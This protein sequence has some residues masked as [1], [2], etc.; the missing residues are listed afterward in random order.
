VSIYWHWLFLGGISTLLVL[1][2]A[3]FVACEFSLI[4]LRYSHFNPELLEELSN[5][6]RFAPLLSRV[7]NALRFL[8]LGVTLCTVGLGLVAWPA[9][10]KLSHL[11]GYPEASWPGWV[12]LIIILSGAIG[13]RHI[14]GELIPRAVALRFP[15]ETLRGTVWFV[16]VLKW[17]VSPLSALLDGGAR[18]ILKVLGIDPGTGWHLLD[19]EMQ[20]R[21][22]SEE[23]G[24]SSDFYPRILKSVLGMRELVV[25][26]VMLPRS[27][28]QY[29]DIYD[30]VHDNLMLAREA[31]HTRFPLCE[32]D[33]DNCIGIIHIKDIFRYGDDPTRV[34]FRRIRRPVIYVGVDDLLDGVMEKLLRQK[35]HMA[36]VRDEFGGTVGV[37]TLENLIEQM[38]GN[39]QDEFDSE[40]DLIQDLEGNSFQVDGLT[41]IRELEEKFGVEIDDDEVSTL[42]GVITSELGHIPETGERVVV[43]SLEIEVTEVD[44]RRVI[45]ARVKRIEANEQKDA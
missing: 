45:S 6:K 17:V 39:I 3:L 32:G 27:Q 22:L 40:E 43:N 13:L 1:V 31:G 42:G 35:L 5:T 20:I 23:T 28:I 9:V 37:V 36:L 21:S 44:E 10:L 18:L 8:R 7:D 24:E 38:V 2:T 15:V 16:R 30:G 19:L 33:L 34:D 4:R 14:V 12:A 41:P 11:F 25:Q 26:D 29:F